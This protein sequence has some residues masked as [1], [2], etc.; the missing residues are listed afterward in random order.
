MKYKI[1]LGGKTYEVEVEKGEAMLKAE[2]DAVSPAKEP[3]TEVKTE[4]APVSAPASNN[5]QG[6]NDTLNAPL[7]GTVVKINVSNGASVKKGQTVLVIEAMKME[8]E[9]MADKDGTIKEVY[10]TKG[11]SVERGTALVL[12][13]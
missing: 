2:Y 11:Q 9:I 5:V 12:I 10:V 3:V 4:S 7:P 13:G 1:T 6:S 8:N